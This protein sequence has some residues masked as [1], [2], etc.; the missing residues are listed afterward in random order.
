MAEI[1]SVK[2]SSMISHEQKSW[3]KHLWKTEQDIP[4]RLEDAAKFLATMIS[5]SFSFFI[6][7]GKTAVTNA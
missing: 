4:N 1:K 2:A 6:A 7:I 3:L 5:I